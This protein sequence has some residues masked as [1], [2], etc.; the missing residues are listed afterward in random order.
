[1]TEPKV[2]FERE[3]EDSLKTMLSHHPFW[4]DVFLS[5]MLYVGH[6]HPAGYNHDNS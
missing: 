4:G 6:I 3:A 5:R 2:S 1:M